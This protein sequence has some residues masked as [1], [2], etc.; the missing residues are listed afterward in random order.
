M[1]GTVS[2]FRNEIKYLINYKTYL[3]LR[4]RLK[5]ILQNDPHS[6]EYNI[7]SL[8]F[9]DI[10]ES[11]FN[12]RLDGIRNREKYRIRIYDFSNEMIKLE[13]KARMGQFI[14]KE[15][16]PITMELLNSILKHNCPRDDL[17]GSRLLREFYLK[18][19]KDILRPS[20]I[21]EYNREAYVCS[22]ENT[23]I[24]FDKALK[25]PMNSYDLFE[26]GCSSRSLLPPGTMILEVK[27]DRFLP[28]YIGELLQISSS[29]RMSIS[30]YVLCRA[31]NFK[32]GDLEWMEL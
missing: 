29:N 24:T 15:A 9:D 23:R 12:D 18:L 31:N 27:F 14:Y 26:K 11:A 20:V 30:K 1:T 5:N 28:E 13:K 4:E 16:A 2:G 25:C 6:K 21:V 19:R 7:R 32:Q 3:L 22:L 17:M 10:N 8:Y